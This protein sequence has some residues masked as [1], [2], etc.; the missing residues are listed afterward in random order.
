MSVQIPELH[1][2]RVR[3]SRWAPVEDWTQVPFASVFADHMLVAEYF[4]GEWQNAC[5][6]PYGPLTLSP[7]ISALQYG[8]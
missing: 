7:T 2:E 1:I 8:V 6:R 3:D 5:I 4:G